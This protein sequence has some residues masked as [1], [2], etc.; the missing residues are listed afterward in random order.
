[1]TPF[2]AYQLYIGIK[3]HF[4]TATYDWFLYNKKVRSTPQSFK[5][6]HDKY[7][8]YKLSKHADPEGLL[9][10]NCVAG[11]YYIKNIVDRETGI[12]KYNQWARKM[13]SLTYEFQNELDKLQNP[14][15]TA[16][17]FVDGA[18]PEILEKLIDE[19]IS[20]ETVCILAKTFK[21]LSFWQKDNIDQHVWWPVQ[22]HLIIRY[23][24]FIKYDSLKIHQIIRERMEMV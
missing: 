4:S 10:A 14:L 13:Q 17:R 24:P 2:E 20:L 15:L 22:Q 12:V 1:M 19:T 23:T 16:V 6:R 8:F 3:N 11:S 21:L 9:V 18:I 5:K 7:E